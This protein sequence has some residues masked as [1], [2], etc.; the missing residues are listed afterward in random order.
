MLNTIKVNPTIFHSNGL[1]QLT[2]SP[3]ES[4]SYVSCQNQGFTDLASCRDQTVL[5]ANVSQ[6][7][8]NLIA[9]DYLHYL[10]REKIFAALELRA[11]DRQ[12]CGSCGLG[13]ALNLAYCYRAGFGVER[14]PV[15]ADYWLNE[16]QTAAQLLKKDPMELLRKDPVGKYPFDESKSASLGLQNLL[17]RGLLD[18]S[19]TDQ[20]TQGTAIDKMIRKIELE[21]SAREVAFGE[22]FPNTLYL[23]LLLSM[24]LLHAGRIDE[25]LAI[26][27]GISGVILQE[28]GP[29]SLNY[30]ELMSVQAQTLMHVGALDQAKLIQQEHLVQTRKACGE[31]HP[32]TVRSMMDLAAINADLSEYSE[33]EVLQTAGLEGTR[34]IFG[35]THPKTV[36]AM[37]TV[38]SIY[39]DQGRLAEAEALALEAILLSI[40]SSGSSHPR[41]LAASN[42]LANVYFAQ[43]RL[44]EAE[45]HM[46]AVFE[47]RKLLLGADHA[48][49]LE[50]C[51]NL[52]TLRLQQGQW[53]A[54]EDLLSLLYGPCQRVLGFGSAITLS[55]VTNLASL[56]GAQERWE[57][58]EDMFLELIEAITDMRGEESNALLAP[59]SNLAQTY[60]KA[61]DIDA[62]ES[63][64]RKAVVLGERIYKSAHA[65]V[66]A[67]SLN[68]AA[69][70]KSLNRLEEAEALARKASDQFEQLLGK[71]HQRTRNAKA[72]LDQIVAM[73]PN[74]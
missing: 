32:D 10:V 35:S 55:A 37:T 9:Y 22:V 48:D 50:T 40:E 62:A 21:S 49:T 30:R 71:D 17:N 38:C 29:E 61:G 65:T 16:V 66:A 39:R 44:E 27:N 23:K 70:L 24:L 47:G 45:E 52:S 31:E 68:L 15:H 4:Q 57:E 12:T 36:V 60:R 73:G 63:W 46:T 5:K 25:A 64:Q 6:L 13:A 26:Q 11:K 59:M 42:V 3:M 54:A 1:S 69:I 20:L 14:D 2:L 53:D 58:A 7:H 74:A 51:A 67:L 8:N 56:R 41:T 19:M 34:R 72:I 18:F 43:G 33:A 28:Q